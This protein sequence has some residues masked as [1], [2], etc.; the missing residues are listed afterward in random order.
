MLLGTLAESSHKIC[1]R[2]NS[3]DIK[4]QVP[5][6]D[7]TLDARSR[8]DDDEDYDYQII[9]AAVK[10][11]AHWLEIIVSPS[12]LSLHKSTINCLSNIFLITLS[13]G[14]LIRY[15]SAQMERE[16]I[17][18]FTARGPCRRSH[19]RCEPF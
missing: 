9:E 10:R 1:F 17:P 18:S 8:A 6:R 12:S 3:Q 15:M 7:H 5:Y 16:D 4:V 19:T 2:K 14:P 11:N 13:L